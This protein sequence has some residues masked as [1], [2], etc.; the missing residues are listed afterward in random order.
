MSL[1]DNI[2]TVD[3]IGIVLTKP[4]EI[5]DEFVITKEFPTAND[6]SRWIESQAVGNKRPLM[7]IIIS[8]CAE[9]D[10]DVESIAPL[11]DPLLKEWLRSEAEEAGLIKKTPKLDL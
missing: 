6:F 2:S 7:D 9:K 10:I 3:Q 11:I 5:T 8:Y 1:Y 4:N